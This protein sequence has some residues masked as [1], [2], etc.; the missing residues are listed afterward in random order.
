MRQVKL[1]KS[2]DLSKIMQLA[3]ARAQHLVVYSKSLVLSNTGHD[4]ESCKGSLVL[5]P[6]RL[7]GDEGGDKSRR[8]DGS[9]LVTM[10]ENRR[11][12]GSWDEGKGVKHNGLCWANGGGRHSKGLWRRR[13]LR[14][15]FPL[16]FRQG[17]R[18]KLF[19]TRKPTAGEHFLSSL[20][21]NH[22]KERKEASD[23]T[24]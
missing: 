13:S 6:T 10:Q 2:T 4:Y 19:N 5:R 12:W 15:S 8:R 1:R 7:R 9:T 16:R 3:S 20:I 18:V 23:T 22:Y 17:Q 11:K 14:M 24:P 21:L